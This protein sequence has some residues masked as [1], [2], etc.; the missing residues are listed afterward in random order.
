M[1]ERLHRLRRLLASERGYTLIE[2]LQV[3]VILGVVL[4]SIM[5]LFVNATNA[6]VDM[7]RRFQAQQ[8]TRI[9]VDRMRREIHCSNAITPTGASS[10]ITV[11]LPAQCAGTGGVQ[12]NIT[13]D[14]S[15][16]STNRYT[17]RR[18]GVTIADY[19]TTANAFNYTA[20][21]QQKLGI[22]RVDLPVNVKPS[23]P[24][25]TWRLVSDIVLRNTTRLP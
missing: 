14:T 22:L 6:E 23:E 9:A 3:T 10:A 7:N 2:L 20:P 16:V 24:H 4:G 25:K 18:N 11:T 13:Y 12:V 17:L 19:V 8:G 5:I 15:L 1:T 21:T